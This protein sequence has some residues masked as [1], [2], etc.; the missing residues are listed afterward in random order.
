MERMMKTWFIGVLVAS[1]VLML[2]I[3]TATQAQQC[4]AFNGMTEFQKQTVIWAYNQGVKYDWGYTLAATAFK[5]SSAGLYPLNVQDPSAGIFHN[6]V[7]YAVN[8]EPDTFTQNTLAIK[9]VL[10]PWLSAEY[11]IKHLHWS[12]QYLARQNDY[13]W[14]NLWAAYNGGI[15]YKGSD[16]TS[17]KND[18]KEYIKKLLPCKLET[19]EYNPIKFNELYAQNLT[20]FIYNKS[21]ELMD[22][23]Y[24]EKQYARRLIPD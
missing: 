18:L 14:D 20:K 13:S 19:Y 24:Y 17:Y 15:N 22:S 10:D 3:S 1:L 16:A 21:F 7:T 12:T 5:E 6:N 4:S 2:T 8:Y 23:M 11:A 9:L